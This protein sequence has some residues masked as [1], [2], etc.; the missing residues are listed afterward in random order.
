MKK[1][2]VLIL[3]SLTIATCIFYIN[4]NVIVSTWYGKLFEITIIAL[5]VFILIALLYYFN[6]AMVKTI[7]RLR[8]KKSPPDKEGL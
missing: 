8:N 6:N 1:L 4:S 2:F 7:T 3:I 5:P